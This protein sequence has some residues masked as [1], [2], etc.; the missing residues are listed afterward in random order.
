MTDPDILSPPGPRSGFELIRAVGE[1]VQAANQGP[2][3][4]A[5]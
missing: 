2:P 4:R 5:C 3:P 1:V